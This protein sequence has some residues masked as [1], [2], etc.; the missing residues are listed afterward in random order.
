MVV[1]GITPQSN[2]MWGKWLKEYQ[3]SWWKDIE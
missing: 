2:E 3:E 1:F